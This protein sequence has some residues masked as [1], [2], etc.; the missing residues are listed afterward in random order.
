MATLNNKITNTM[1]KKA[2]KKVTLRGHAN[3]VCSME[4]QGVTLFGHSWEHKHLTTRSVLH[5]VQGMSVNDS[6]SKDVRVTNTF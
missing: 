1:Y 4:A 6:K 3:F 2:K 5:S